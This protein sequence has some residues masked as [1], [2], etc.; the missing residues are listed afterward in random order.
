MGSVISVCNLKGGAGNRIDGR[1]KIA[2][3]LFRYERFGETVSPP[4]H[5]RMA[6]AKAFDTGQWV[7][8]FAPGSA[9]HREIDTLAELVASGYSVV[10][11][12]A[13]F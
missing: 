4:I 2:R 1:T 6:F 9:A 10:R 8:N 11:V 12:P 7:G 3:E 5:M 13:G